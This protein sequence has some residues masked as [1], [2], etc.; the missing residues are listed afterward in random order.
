MFNHQHKQTLTPTA[1]TTQAEYEATKQ[2]LTERYGEAGQFPNLFQ[3]TFDDN[4]KTIVIE[5]N[6]KGKL[7]DG[8]WES[9]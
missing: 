8:V 5:K 6:L 9:L 3:L 1:Q 7:I 2:F 4:T